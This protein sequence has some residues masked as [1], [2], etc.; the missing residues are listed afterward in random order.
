MELTE[1]FGTAVK[2]GDLVT[3]RQ[4]VLPSEVNRHFDASYVTSTPNKP[5]TED[6]AWLQVHFDTI[7]KGIDVASSRSA[8][9]LGGNRTLAEVR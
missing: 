6:V 2:E 4:A 8:R 3:V 9:L 5:C 1:G 7:Y